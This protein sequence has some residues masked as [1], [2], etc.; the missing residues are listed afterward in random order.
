MKK[1]FPSDK[2]I[3]HFIQLFKPA[4]MEL[5]YYSFGFC[6]PFYMKKEKSNFKTKF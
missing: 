4:F 6:R 2:I 5:I 1:K 3:A